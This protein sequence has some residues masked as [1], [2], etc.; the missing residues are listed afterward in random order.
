MSSAPLHTYLLGGG[1]QDWGLWGGGSDALWGPLLVRRRLRLLLCLRPRLALW[2]PRPGQHDGGGLLRRRRLCLSWRL[3][4]H[5]CRAL[6][7]L[8]LGSAIPHRK[9]L[10]GILLGLLK[11]LLGM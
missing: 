5:R 11:G 6:L 3:E 7:L 2:L 4:H 10:G 8:Q 1:A 9:C